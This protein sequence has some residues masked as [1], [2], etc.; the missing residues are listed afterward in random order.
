MN[1]Y[2]Y[3]NHQVAVMLDANEAETLT[4]GTPEEQDAVLKLLQS[5]VAAAYKGRHSKE[6]R[7]K[8]DAIRP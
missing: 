8:A 5:K 4:N 6:P 3:A 7:N 2:P 1:V